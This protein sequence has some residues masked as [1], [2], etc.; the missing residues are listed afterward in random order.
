LK[1]EELYDA[2][3]AKRPCRSSCPDAEGIETIRFC[4]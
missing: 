1:H 2:W 3:A 4:S